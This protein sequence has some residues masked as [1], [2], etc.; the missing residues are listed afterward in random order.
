MAAVGPLSQ[1]LQIPTIYLV[2]RVGGRKALVFIPKILG[3]LFWVLIALT[4][5]LLPRPWHIPIFLTCLVLYF[6]LGAISDCA[7]NSWMRDAIPEKYMGRFTAKSMGVATTVGAVITLAAGFGLEELR[8]LW[9]SAT[10]PYSILFLVGAA[11]GLLGVFPIL[12]V[13]EPRSLKLGAEGLVARLREP[14]KEANFR[15]VLIFSATWNFAISMAGAFYAVYLIKSL[16]LSMPFIV[17]LSV[18]SKV[19]NVACLKAW[20]RMADR[21][22]SRRTLSIAGPPFILCIF[23]LPFTTLPEQHIMTIPLLVIIYVLSGISTAGVTVSAGNLALKTAPRGRATAYLAVNSLISGLAAACAPVLGG[24]LA[25]FF[26]RRE[27]SVLIDFS[28]GPESFRVLALSLREL[29]F[30]FFLSGF[31][32]IYALHRLTLIKEPTVEIADEDRPG[33]LNREVPR[34]YSDVPAV[35][36]VSQMGDFPYARLKR[37]AEPPPDGR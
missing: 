26:A 28:G 1:I 13:P 11:A 9:P 30:V 31:V 5:L 4:P 3:R 29:D 17:S 6:S 2:E 34:T 15:S 21:A 14:L 24:W 25:D 18:G 27:F 10:G 35:A 7:F 22:G 37:T 19:A 20:G 23:L 36:G 8:S 32:G 12:R 33:T 16:G